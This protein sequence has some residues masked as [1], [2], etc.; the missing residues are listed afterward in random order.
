[1]V[2]PK[3][4]TLN[5]RAHVSGQS[6]V[7]VDSRNIYLGRTGDPK[8]LARYA[9]FVSDYQSNGLIVP[10]GFNS[11]AVDDRAE[12][13]LSSASS[14]DEHL[15][16]EPLTV[17]HLCEAYKVHIAK[18]YSGAH[19]SQDLARKNRVVDD[20]LENDSQTLVEKFGP[21][22]LKAIRQRWIDSKIISRKYA[23]RLTNEAK[24]MFR[25][26]VAE[27]IVQPEVVV[28]L[29]ALAP[30]QGGEGSKRT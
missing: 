15:D 27:E 22:K 8:T 3:S 14:P 9:M 23:N 29:E 10:D 19:Q 28:A 7:R 4:E 2:R 30:L 1:M 17:G 20:I 25:W 11:R 16:D 26:G 5:L 6:F 13:L 18:R 24:S 21:K 12:L